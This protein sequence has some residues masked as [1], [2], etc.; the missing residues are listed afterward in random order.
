MKLHLPPLLFSALV[1]CLAVTSLHR[2]ISGSSSAGASG[3]SVSFRTDQQEISS[4]TTATAQAP[5]TG[6]SVVYN[7]TPQTKLDSDFSI[8]ATTVEVEVE[9]PRQHD[10]N[11]V[12]NNA[13]QTKIA[14]ANTAT[15]TTTKKTAPANTVADAFNSTNETDI[16]PFFEVAGVGNSGIA[17]AAEDTP[18]TASYEDNT[19]TIVSGQNAAVRMNENDNTTTHK[20]DSYSREGK[21]RPG[22]ARWAG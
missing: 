15:A 3:S 21:I 4:Q 19:L 10:I 14:T 5:T 9:T 17:L 11:Q 16:T 6:N 20:T 13:T 7:Y 22:K 12:S 8:H 1:A 2:S 18:V